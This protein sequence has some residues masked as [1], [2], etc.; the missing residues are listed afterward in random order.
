[1]LINGSTFVVKDLLH[2]EARRRTVE[3]P[4]Q[5]QMLIL[6]RLYRQLDDWRLTIEDFAA[7][8]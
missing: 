8:I 7:A 4:Q 5:S 3:Q 1:M 6:R 2:P